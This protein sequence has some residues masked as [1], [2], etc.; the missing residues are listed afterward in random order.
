ML[1]KASK[2]AN[3]NSIYEEGIYNLLLLK[4]T[5]TLIL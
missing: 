4:T 2:Q 3:Y 5:I 1:H